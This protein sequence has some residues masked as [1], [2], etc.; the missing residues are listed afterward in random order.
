MD[1]PPRQQYAALP[2]RRGENGMMVLLVTSR[3][4]GRWVLPKGWPK[5]QLNGADTA[6]LEAFEEA[7][8][9]GDVAPVSIGIYRY[10]KRMADGHSVACVVDVFALCV[11]DILDDWP[12]RGQRQRRWFSFAEAAGLVEEDDLATLLRNLATPGAISPC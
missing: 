2:C 7:G 6:A 9:K 11:A 4:T 5:K 3:E 10:G 1:D 12:E 8:I